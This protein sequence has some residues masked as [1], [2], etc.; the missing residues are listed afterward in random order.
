M[1]NLWG[2]QV[3]LLIIYCILLIV[4]I[5][6]YEYRFFGILMDSNSP[7]EFKKIIDCFNWATSFQTWIVSPE[8]TKE[9][10]EL[11]FQLGHVFSDMDSYV[12]KGLISSL[13]KFQL[14]HVF[15]DMDRAAIF[16]PLLLSKKSRFSRISLTSY[17]S[18]RKLTLD[19]R[20]F[21]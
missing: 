14:G 6:C 2:V 17:N 5:F 3:R 10:H 1:P 19:W 15:S 7:M 9:Y 16:R 20:H 13:K 21:R 11:L 4:F 18:F 12:K 8:S